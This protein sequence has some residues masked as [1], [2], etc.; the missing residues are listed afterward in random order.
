[1]LESV[2]SCSPK[3]K[4]VMVIF[5][6]KFCACQPFYVPFWHNILKK[7]KSQRLTS[8]N[9]T[10][11]LNLF[12]QKPTFVMSLCYKFIPSIFYLNNCVGLML[13]THI[14]LTTHVLDGGTLS[15]APLSTHM[16]W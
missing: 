2:G 8:E 7:K 12:V 11:L 6:Y 13:S 1:M 4:F 9:E 3:P 14:V 15:M 5:H 10:S 16:F